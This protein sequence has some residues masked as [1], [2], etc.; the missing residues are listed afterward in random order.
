M[1][2]WY[3]DPIIVAAVTVVVLVSF[4][5]I[6]YALARYRSTVDFEKRRDARTAAFRAAYGGRHGNRPHDA[7]G[8][9]LPA[10]TRVRFGRRAYVIEDDG[11][12]TGI[13]IADELLYTLADLGPST[14]PYTVNTFVQE[15]PAS[16]ASYQDELLNPLNPMSPLSPLNQANYVNTWHEQSPIENAVQPVWGDTP[17]PDAGRTVESWSQPTAVE[18]SVSTYEPSASSD[19]G[20]S[21]SYDS[22]SS[23]GCDSGGGGCD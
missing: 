17:S 22:G 2:T 7:S 5:L 4:T 1:D 12:L 19:Y 9:P 14:F 8:N 3:S 21:S 11:S 10:R 18:Q 6:A 16:V 13:D 20:S 15:A 23:G